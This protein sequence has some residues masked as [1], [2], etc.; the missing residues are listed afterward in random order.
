MSKFL[1]I[2]EPEDFILSKKRII[3]VFKQN[4]DIHTKTFDSVN[5]KGHITTSQAYDHTNYEIV[6]EMSD[7]NNFIIS[8]DSEKKQN[9]IWENI[10]EQLKEE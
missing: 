4:K 6:I 10:A 8:F 3:K 5:A 9:K 2:K 1:F 7:T